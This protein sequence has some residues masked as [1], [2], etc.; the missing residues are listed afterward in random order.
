ML[1]K[2]NSREQ[3]HRHELTFASLYFNTALGLLTCMI[4]LCHKQTTA[5]F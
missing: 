5:R 4:Y 3:G 2:V 1:H